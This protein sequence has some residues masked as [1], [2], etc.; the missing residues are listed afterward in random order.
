M[1]TVFGCVTCV[2]EMEF[3]ICLYVYV[4]PSTKVNFKM[5]QITPPTL[6]HPSLIL[7][8]ILQKTQMAA[9]NFNFAVGRSFSFSIRAISPSD[10]YSGMLKSRTQPNRALPQQLQPLTALSGSGAI[11]ITDGVAI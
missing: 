6:D 2:F 3:L 7:T 9:R 5:P 1:Q 8:D 11:K 4:E 10:D